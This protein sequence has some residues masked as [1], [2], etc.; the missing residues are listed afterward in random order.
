MVANH[1][2]PDRTPTR[3]A[4][5]AGTGRVFATTYAGLVRE[6]ELRLPVYTDMRWHRRDPWAPWQPLDTTELDR[7]LRGVRV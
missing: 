5:Q 6:T 2:E 3:Q 1:P 7:W 4:R